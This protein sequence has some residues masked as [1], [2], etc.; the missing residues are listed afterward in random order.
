MRNKIFLS[1]LMFLSV[2]MAWSQSLHSE[3]ENTLTDGIL[4]LDLG[5]QGNRVRIGGF[6]SAG[7]HFTEI[8]NA[9]SDN[10]FNI[11]NAF[12][13]LEG[14]F[15]NDKLGFFLQADFADS[16]PLLDAYVTYRP[17]KDL[18][19]SVGQK[20]TFTNSRDLMLHDQSTA[21]GEHSP[22]SQEFNERGRELGAYAEYRL[23]TTRL[24]VDL[25]LAVTS[26][27]GRNSFGSSSTDPDNGSLKYGGRVTVY[28]M[29]YFKRGN[30]LVFFD[31]IREA[32]PK[33]AIG[34]AFSYNN[35]ASNAKG[36]GHGDFTMYD[37]E[38]NAAYPGLRKLTADLLFKW[39]GFTFLADYT[40]TTGAKLD[41]LY[42]AAN[43]NAK[44]QPEE[45]SQYLALGNGLD[46]QAGY[47]TKSLWA[48]NFGYSY[49]KPEFAEVANSVLRRMSS[50]DIGI[51]KFF[52]KNTFRL[53]LL[54]NYTHYHKEVM[55]PYKNRSIKMNL[56]I[57]F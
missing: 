19:F 9:E 27:D 2:N 46:V 7:G 17:I 1:A 56:Q 25:G 45:I 54:G 31:F 13:S 34:G 20:Q 48:V 43:V 6:V 12:L 37:R 50:Y 47:I 22:M 57:M 14:S 21:T 29:G 32:T 38:G 35:G 49:V 52:C 5:G 10:G 28:P 53:Q 24:G 18:V 36:E 3:A 30:E 42:T 23:P 40:N 26:G 39:Q 41:N 16:Y 8:K 44:L 55:T 33:L 11:D 51:S 15:L 4:N